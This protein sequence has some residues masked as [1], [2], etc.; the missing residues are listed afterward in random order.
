M[1]QGWVSGRGLPG[2]GLSGQESGAARADGEPLTAE[3]VRACC[4][5]RLAHYKIPRH[6]HLVDGFPMTVT[7]KI[8]KVEMREAALDLLGLHDAANT[9]NA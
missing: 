1:C 5:G 4:L 8:R 2:P 3:S 9:R 7:G 6:V